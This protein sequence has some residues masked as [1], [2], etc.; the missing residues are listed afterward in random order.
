[1]ESWIDT[2]PFEQLSPLRRTLKAALINPVANY[3]PAP[4]MRGLLRI[5]KSQFA[6]ANWQDPGGWQSMVLS[7]EANCRQV[8]D[9]VLIN[10]GTMSMALRNRRRLAAAVLGQLFEQAAAEPVQV[11]GLGAGC[12][13]N[14]ADAMAVSKRDVRAVLVDINNAAFQ[15]GQDMVAKMGLADRIRFVQD[16]VRNVASLLDGPV[17]V[18]KLIGILEYLSDDEIR[19]ILAP[20][21]GVM[22]S[23]SAIVFNSLSKAHGTDRFFRRVFD[24][25]MIHRSRQQLQDLIAPAGFGDF[26]SYSEP[27]GVYDVVLGKRN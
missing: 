1:M 14:V 3:T 6:A 25:N 2:L 9:K 26:T 16:D 21:A 27:L 15:Y 19:A 24:L 10:A 22:K 5:T 12:G 8:A 17:D 7:Y 23:G 13:H 4:L 11:L 18:V 20:L